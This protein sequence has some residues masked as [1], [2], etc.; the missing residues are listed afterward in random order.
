LQIVR[1]K[2]AD[3]ESVTEIFCAAQQFLLDPWLP[4]AYIGIVQ[5]SKRAET[6]SRGPGGA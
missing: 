5:C 2:G 4:Q 1:Y 3:G 6:V